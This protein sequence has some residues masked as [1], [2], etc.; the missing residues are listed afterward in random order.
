[1]QPALSY[2]QTTGCKEGADPGARSR[3][4]GLRLGQGLPRTPGKTKNVETRCLE[5][6]MR[7]P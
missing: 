5:S 3:A 7:R 2:L 6:Q 1:M 4:K